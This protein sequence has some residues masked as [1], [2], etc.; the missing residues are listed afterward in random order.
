MAKGKYKSKLQ[1][2][3]KRALQGGVCQRCN[4]EVAILTVDHIVPISILDMLDDTGEMK[5][6]KED[7]FQYLCWPCNRFKAGRI[8]KTCWKTKEILLSLLN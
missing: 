6:E 3:Q 7:N 5:Y 2:W 8:D 1:E 4:R